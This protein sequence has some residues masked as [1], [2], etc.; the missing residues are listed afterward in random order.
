VNVVDPD[1][2][3]VTSVDLDHMDYLGPTREDIGREKAGVFR[4]GRPAVCADPNPPASLLHHASVLGAPLYL[5]GRD[6]G[7]E[8]QG[9]QWRYQGPGGARFGLSMPALRG[10]YQL[11]NAATVLAVLG[12]LHSR[13]PVTA[14]AIREGLLTVE[15]SGRFQVLPGRPTIVL[16]V[17]HNPHAACALAQTLGTMGYHPRTLAVFGILSDKDVAA[18]VAAVRTQID[19]WFVATLPGPRGT[20]AAALASELVRAG[21]PD[22]SVRAFDDVAAAV[23][24]AQG[25]CGEADRIIVFGSFLTVG[26]ALTALRSGSTFAQRHG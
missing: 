14:T 20:S 6:Y 21:I 24:A 18:V 26:A 4:T 16:D 11:T 7:F 10:A 2:A 15:L 25:E 12:L 1:I 17:A 3:V 13:L 5:I 9:T 22:D 19:L 23:R 8:N